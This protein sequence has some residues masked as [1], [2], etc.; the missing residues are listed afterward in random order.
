MDSLIGIV[1]VKGN[2]NVL[3]AY[4]ILGYFIMLFENTNEMHR[5][6]IL[7]RN[8]IHDVLPSVSRHLMLVDK[9]NGVGAL[10]MASNTL[11]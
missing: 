5:I 2:P 6:H 11:G 1:P 7:L 8:H 3:A 9:E 4:P 10:N